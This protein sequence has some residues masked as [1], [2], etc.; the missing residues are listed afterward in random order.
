MILNANAL[1]HFSENDHPLEDFGI[2]L[3]EVVE[4][5]EGIIEAPPEKVSSYSGLEGRKIQ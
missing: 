5:S 2:H 3:F 1:V 4:G